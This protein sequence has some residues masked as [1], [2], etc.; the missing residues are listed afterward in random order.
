M[1]TPPKAFRNDAPDKPMSHQPADIQS[2]TSCH[3]P[4]YIH[5][6]H[7]TPTDR[8]SSYHPSFQTASDMLTFGS[9]LML[10][11]PR[12]RMIFIAARPKVIAKASLASYASQLHVHQFDRGVAQHTKR[13]HQTRPQPSP[14][15]IHARSILCCRAR[16]RGQGSLRTRRPS[17]SPQRQ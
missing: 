11:P 13:K 10:M 3:S 8:H 6:R 15:C 5:Y 16:Q 12:S 4:S 1:I 9:A 14:R 7:F 17:S 2:I